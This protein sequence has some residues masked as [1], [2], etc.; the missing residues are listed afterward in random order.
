[1]LLLTSTSDIVRVV[2][3]T[4]G[5][6][7]ECHA[8]WVDNNAG[9]ITL[10]RTNTA[11]IVTNTT[12][13]IVGSPGASTQRNVKH[14]SA[15]N[16]HASTSTD[17]TVEHF[18][19]TTAETLY[20]ATL[21]PSESLTRDEE[22]W[23]HHYDAN[24]GEYPTSANLATQA[25]MEGAAS[26]INVVTP[27]RQHFHPGHPKF[28]VKCGTTGNILASYGVTTVTDTGV[29]LVRP[30]FTSGAPSFSAALLSH[31]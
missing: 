7:V 5:A 6:D 2:T 12:T 21:L 11:S 18:D 24:G 28:W 30:N 3:G 29:G 27:G 17:V 16:N 10:G 26:L 13:T 4:T 1:M 19:G 15:R 22:G 25:D 23:W 31:A 9:T 20:K 8:S 14:L